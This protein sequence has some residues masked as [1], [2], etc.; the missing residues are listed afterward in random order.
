MYPGTHTRIRYTVIKTRRHALVDVKVNMSNSDEQLR[1][2]RRRSH[3]DLETKKSV[4]KSLIESNDMNEGGPQKCGRLFY[5]Y[6]LERDR[7]P[8]EK[9]P[10]VDVKFKIYRVGCFDQVNSSFFCD[11]IL[12]LDWEDESLSLVPKGQV[13]DFNDFFWPRAELQNMY[14]GEEDLDFSKP[15]CWP[16]YKYDK[17]GKRHR[18][19]ITMKV[20]RTLFCRLDYH[21]YPFDNQVLELTIKLLSVRIPLLSGD[22]GTRPKAC[23]PKRWRGA[24]KR[25]KLANGEKGEV[26]PLGHEMVPES[27]WL[28]EFTFLRMA[29]RAYSSKFGPMIHEGDDEYTSRLAK[30][31]ED[32]YQDTYTLQL[33]IARD[34]K[35]VL[36]N[37]SFSLFVIDVMVFTAHGIPI[38]DL[39]DR[40]SVN[41]TLLLTAMAFKWVLNDGTPNVP[42]LT[43]MECYVVL[44]FSMLFF[45]GV[46][47]WFL[48]DAYNYRCGADEHTGQEASYIDWWSGANETSQIIW[49]MDC[50]HIHY[51]DRGILFLEIL[52]WILKNAWFFWQMRK[53]GNPCGFICRKYFYCCIKC[54]YKL[55]CN[56]RAGADT[57]KETFKDYLKRYCDEYGIVKQDTNFIDL[58][59]MK[60]YRGKHHKYIGSEE[61]IHSVHFFASNGVVENKQI[62]GKQVGPKTTRR[63]TP[64]ITG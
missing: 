31:G 50:E 55:Q 47:F 22:R 41:L 44:T 64:E 19:S 18:A 49:E 13:P 48:S 30:A 20:R 40:L 1:P 11:F 34:S 53:R 9:I 12:M 6:W 14:P 4:E 58:S 26:K 32:F 2:A 7:D 45:Q 21:N 52:L 28:P 5:K 35:N 17:E 27:D 3:I 15:E 25:K 33:V 36:W 24:E 60:E 62:V 54:L 61:Q 63:V 29:A 43:T 46:A 38:E 39:A 8:S 57:S 16:K 51:L 42:Y 56:S 59:Y 37:L 10:E 23:H